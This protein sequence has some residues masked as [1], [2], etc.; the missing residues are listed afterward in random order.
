MFGENLTL[1]GLDESKIMIGD[2]FEFGTA[3]IEVSEPWRPSSILGIRFGTQR[4]VKQFNNSDYSG[5]YVRVLKKG[6]V[7]SGDQLILKKSAEKVSVK[8]VY[9]L[10][11]YN[12]KTQS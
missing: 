7:K 11:S 1:E 6:K 9:S 2:V 8:D 5:M 3:I 12:N 4:I 10:F